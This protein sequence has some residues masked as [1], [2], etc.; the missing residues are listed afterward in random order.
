MV[1][2]NRCKAATLV[3]SAWSDAGAAA[4]LPFPLLLLV[5]LLL[6]LAPLL[7][8]AGLSVVGWDGGSMIRCRLR[9]GD[10]P[11]LLVVASWRFAVVDL[12]SLFDFPT[13]VSLFPP[14]SNKQSLGSDQNVSV[15]VTR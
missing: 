10:S 11:V 8:V 4:P 2:S 1:S 12:G 7:V 14:N 3:G 5:S 6:A 15:N 9:F 13:L